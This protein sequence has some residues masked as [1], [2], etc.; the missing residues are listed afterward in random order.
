[1]KIPTPK[2]LPSG[3]FRIQIRIDGKYRSITASTAKDCKKKAEELKARQILGQNVSGTRSIT[4]SQAID[5]YIQDRSEV[6]SPSTIQGYRVIQK[7]RFK[8]VM[9]HQLKAIKN[10]QAIVNAEAKICSAKTLANSYGLVRSIMINEGM[11]PPNVTLPQIVKKERTWIDADQIPVLLKAVKNTEI[12]TAVILGLHSLRLSEAFSLNVSDIHDGKI[13]VH[14]AV[15]RG[16]NGMVHKETNKNTSSRRNIPV[17]IPRLMEI[18][19]DL[20]S[21]VTVSERTINRHLKLI[22]EE[23]GLPECTM[24]CLRHS[25]VAL[26]VSLNIPVDVVMKLGGWSDYTTLKNIYTHIS[27]ATTDR[28]AEDLKAFFL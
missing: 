28:Y 13:H 3:S 4:L 27:E 12:E 23:K 5:R 9:G 6:L 15:V 19:P 10:W 2:K 14:G 17:L 21:V 18:L 26:C 25:F 11:T 1:M 20:G 24:H 22:C 16:T 8:A 7:N